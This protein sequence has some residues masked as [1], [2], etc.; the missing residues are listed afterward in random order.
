MNAPKKIYSIIFGLLCLLFCASF[1][2]GCAPSEETINAAQSKVEEADQLA[3][4]HQYIDAIKKYDEARLLDE[5]N[6]NAYTGIANVY[7]TKNRTKDAKDTLAV[8]VS[9]S[10][11]PSSAYLLLGKLQLEENDLD[12]AKDSFQKAVSSDSQNSEAKYL[13]AVTL[14]NKGDFEKARDTLD[15]PEDA[16]IF[17]EAEL[18]KAVLL[19]ENIADAKSLISG[20][21]TTTME[22]TVLAGK[23][24]KYL[25]V[26]DKIEQVPAD[27]Q[28]DKYTDVLLASGAINAGYEDV[29]LDLLSP[30]KDEVIEYWELD[31]YL[32]QAHYMNNESDEAITYL[33]DACTLNPVD[34]LSPWLLGRI[35][36][37]KSNQSSMVESYARAISLASQPDKTTI[38]LEY[39][40][41][42]VDAGLYTQ[43]DEQYNALI[44]E[45]AA[46]AVT[47]QLLRVEVLLDRDTTEAGVIDQAD[48]ILSQLDI[49]SLSNQKKADYNWLKG[50]SVYAKGT[51]EDAKSWVNEAISIDGTN[52]KYH[53]L[54]GEILFE[55]GS[56]DEARAEL[57]KAVDLDTE[58]YV[59]GEASNTLDRI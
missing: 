46:N 17:P 41:L 53:L 44:S 26:L 39:A 49:N 52:A 27:E 34:Y 2:S 29:A 9:K 36:Q 31:L 3:A 4:N 12:A 11:N 18:L 58:G 57:E 55:E 50:L 32:G 13:L 6:V 38:R 16:A 37:E 22:D 43:A 19:R 24:T 10:R 35:Y 5:G 25:E 7:V 30:Y 23:I 15:I 8:G 28:S 42:L 59:S 47:Y 1:L 40:R 48:A 20:F 54:L 45:D 51:P 56:T 14:V 33:E 21:D